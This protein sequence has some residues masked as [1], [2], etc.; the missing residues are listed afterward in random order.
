MALLHSARL[1]VL[2]FACTCAAVAQ[3][4][5]K[6]AAMTN[7]DVIA[8]SAAG[9]DEGIVIAKIN[10]APST[11]FDT[12]VTGLKAL[13]AAGVPLDVVKTMISPAAAHAAAIA[14]ALPDPDDFNQVQPV[15]IYA[16]ARKNGDSGHLIK[17][18]YVAPLKLDRKVSFPDYKLVANF[19]HPQATVELN[20]TNPTFYIYPK[21]DEPSTQRDLESF[22]LVKLNV[23][24]KDRDFSL[25][26]IRKGQVDKQI[27]QE[28]KLVQLKPRIYKVTLSKPLEPGEY[29]FYQRG[30]WQPGAGPVDGG[31]YFEF[32]AGNEK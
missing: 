3:A 18:G 10:S 29:V 23:N 11:N 6:P 30:T 19:D 13:K 4:P 15:G 27:I 31:T 9:L 5:A 21:A 22:L 8:L 26:Q 25:G 1:L 7:D 17:L 12:S 14:D 24:K 20:D 28:T 32:G 2:A 16:Y